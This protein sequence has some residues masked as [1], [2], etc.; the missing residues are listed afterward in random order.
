MAHGQ[1]TTFVH[2]LEKKQH[3]RDGHKVT[4]LGLVLAK[5]LETRGVYLL[6]SVQKKLKK[7]LTLYCFHGKF[8]LHTV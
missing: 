2:F 1:K 3:R 5:P 6:K 7:L 4:L 8:N